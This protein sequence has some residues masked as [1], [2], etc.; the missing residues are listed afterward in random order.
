MPP[1]RRPA[2]DT[3][4]LATKETEQRPVSGMLHQNRGRSRG[5]RSPGR[6]AGSAG[7]LCPSDPSL[8]RGAGSG[9]APGGARSGHGV[10]AGTPP[11][12]LISPA[13]RTLARQPSRR[14]PRP[15]PGMAVTPADASS[16]DYNFWVRH[17]R[18]G[19]TGRVCEFRDRRYLIYF[20]D[21]GA[22]DWRWADAFPSV[23]HWDRRSAQSA[24]DAGLVRVVRC[25]DMLISSPVQG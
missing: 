21:T 14:E 17:F 6:G 2:T 24:A 5:A 22:Y 8:G 18:S 10:G 9:Q 1:Q 13:P 16:F 4:S 12:A 11:F 19:R 3:L 15:L 20:P 25:G 23:G 7:I